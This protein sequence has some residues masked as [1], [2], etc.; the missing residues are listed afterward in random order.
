MHG[1]I[2]TLYQEIPQECLPEEYGGKAGTVAELAGEF[3][4]GSS[5]NKRGPHGSM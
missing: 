1:D 3:T 2:E 5:C 4:G